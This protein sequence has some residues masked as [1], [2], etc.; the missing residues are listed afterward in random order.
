MVL[1][2]LEPLDRLAADALR[3]RV[4][5]DEIG[6]VGLDRAELVEQGVVDVVADERVIEDVV[7]VVELGDPLPQLGAP[8]R[9]VPAPSHAPTV[10]RTCSRASSS[11][12]SRTASRRGRAVRSK[13]SGVIAI[14]PRATAARSQEPVAEASPA[15]S[16]AGA[17]VA[18]TT[19]AGLCTR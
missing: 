1:V 19:A 12:R 13:C 16:A 11:R 7:G 6:M 9:H 8:R 17:A 5:G 2:L 4:G 10:A 18:G 15:V 14:L 3:R